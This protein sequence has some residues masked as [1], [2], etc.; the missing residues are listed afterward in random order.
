VRDVQVVA[1]AVVIVREAT[2]VVMLVRVRKEVLQES[3]HQASVVASVVVVVLPRL[4]SGLFI[5]SARGLE[6][7]Q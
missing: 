6:D 1:E 3:S 7:E 4:R 5:H 2:V